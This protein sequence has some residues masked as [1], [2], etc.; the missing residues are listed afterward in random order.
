MRL[1]LRRGDSPE[2][3]DE[4]AS[5]PVDE[6]TGPV[7]VF[8]RVIDGD[9]LWLAIQDV[10]L[11]A[12]L[13]LRWASGTVTPLHDDARG[14]DPRRLTLR[15]ALDTVSFA[16][17]G[18]PQPIVVR[19][20]GADW[21]PLRSLPLPD[22]EP[23][24]VPRSRE[25]HWAYDVVRDENGM[26]GLT[27]TAA[28]A[29]A[30]LVGMGIDGEAITLRVRIE[31]GSAFLRLSEEVVELAG[32]PIDGCLDLRIRAEDLP[33]AGATTAQLLVRTPDGDVP[34]VRP[35]HDLTQASR[36]V[37]CPEIHAGDDEQPRLRVRFDRQGRLQVRSRGT[38][39]GLA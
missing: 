37:A 14:V 3:T 6:P 29:A 23:V 20:S 30:A 24:L 19:E 8:A 33:A 7:A 1:G 5:L 31:A 34:V 25:G 32:T 35:R 21:Q 18:T 22:L 38:G 2:T 17:D 4:L 9:S 28:L 11:D 13:G 39:A 26:I 10:A 36:A 12:E 16:E 15:T 27:R